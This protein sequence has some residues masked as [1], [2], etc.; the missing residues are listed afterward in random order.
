MALN[1]IISK[2]LNFLNTDALADD[3]EVRVNGADLEYRNSST[4]YRSLKE[5]ASSTDLQDALDGAASPS[6]SK[7][8]ATADSDTQAA[9][10]GAAA[11]TGANV[12]A[13]MA[14]ISGGGG[15][16]QDAISFSISNKWNAS[17]NHNVSHALGSVP[18]SFKCILATDLNGGGVEV[19]ISEGDINGDTIMVDTM[20]AYAGPTSLPAIRTD[21]SVY[22]N[23]NARIS[24][25]TSS[26]ITITTGDIGEGGADTDKD[27]RILV[28]L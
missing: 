8:F 26:N 28:R 4:N 12:F 17:F 10:D 5:L 23:G 22:L 24:A 16:T 21:G 3:G 14:D 7:P 2:L 11:P 20:A 13:T 25:G 15:L 6:T 9:L 27:Y 18:T 1:K 19:H